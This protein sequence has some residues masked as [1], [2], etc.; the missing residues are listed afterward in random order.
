V[1][2][3]N[4]AHV[5]RVLIPSSSSLPLPRAS[6]GALAAQD[7]ASKINHL[8]QCVL[9]SIELFALTFFNRDLLGTHAT[10]VGEAAAVETDDAEALLAK[11]GSQAEVSWTGKA[12]GREPGA[13]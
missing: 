13:G 4:A 10:K 12:A 2:Q 1:G 8:R 5:W 7:R 11:G 3:S 6:H 9:P